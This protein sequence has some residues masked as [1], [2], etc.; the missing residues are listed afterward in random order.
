LEPVVSDVQP[1]TTFDVGVPSVARMYDYALG[2]KDNF[3]VDRN[4]VAQAAK[5][6]P[7]FREVAQ[8][9]RGFLRRSVRHM[10]RQG[11]GQFIDIGSG[12]PTAG[13]THE[14][15]Q[16]INPATRVV[17]VDIDPVVLVHGRA[18]LD[19]NDNTAVVTADMRRPDDVLGHE[20]TRRLIDFSRPVGVLLIAMVHFLN[21]E[22]AAMVIG[23]L[24]DELPPGSYL[25]MT[26]T[27]ADGRSREA[28]EQLNNIYKGS[29]T[30]LYFRSRDEL[31]GLVDGFDLAPPGIVPLDQWH[32]DPRDPVPTTKWLYGL[33]GRR[34]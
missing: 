15:A 21:P 33:V 16:S 5:V 10:V 34:P 7:D 6:M 29:D 2:G 27:T 32:P 20:D 26:H 22:E 30:R 1:P 31:A 8:E 3:E 4:A 28:F 9:N 14:I 24:R 19:A 25:S 18:L 11:V 23:R 12:L 13:N 17:Y